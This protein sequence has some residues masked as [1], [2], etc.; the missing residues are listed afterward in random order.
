MAES[1]AIIP[2]VKNKEG[3][4]VDSILFKDLLKLNKYNRQD[5]VNA[6]LMTKSK[7]FSTYYG[8]KVEY[9]ENNEPKLNSL[10][11]LPEFKTI[12]SDN[13]IIE[14]LNKEIGH[15]KKDSNNIDY[16]KNNTEN[17]QSL[18]KKAIDFNTSAKYKDYIALIKKSQDDKGNTLLT[19]EVEKKN[20]INSKEASDMQ[21]FY[22]LNQK[23][24]EIMHD[25]GVTDEAL[26]DIEERLGINGVTDFEKANVTANGLIAII[27]L[28]KGER[29]EKALPEEFAHLMIKAL[30]DNPLAKRLR[31]V[32][33]K[34][35]LEAEILGE[36]YNTYS[37]QY[38]GNR[39]KLIEEAMGK[40]VANSLIN[41]Q[42]I[43]QAPYKP[44][45]QRLIQAIKNFF[46]NWDIDR[47]DRAK[48]EANKVSD[49]IAT[50]LLNNKLVDRKDIDNISSSDKFYQ[51]TEKVK[52]NKELI[53]SIIQTEAKRLKIFETKN[54]ETF[55]LKQQQVIL[56][57]QKSLKDNTE[58]EALYEYLDETFNTLQKVEAKLINLKS[59]SDVSINTLARTLND[60]KDFLDA[61]GSVFNIIR[62]R[63]VEDNKYEDSQFDDNLKEVLK[64][65]DD[66]LK[67]LYLEYKNYSMPL[68]VQFIKPWV[69]EGIVIPF[70][71][72]KGKI[73]TAEDMVKR[74]DQDISFFDRWLKSMA[75][76]SDP[77]LNILD[78]IVK[79]QKNEA[80]LNTIEISKKI[81]ALG[82]E[83]EQAGVKG[84]D[85]MFEKNKEGKRT[86]NY[87]QEINYGEFKE[88]LRKFWDELNKKYGENPVDEE[89]ILNRKKE[90]REWYQENT[91]RAGEQTIP[92]ISK[93]KNKEYEKLNDAQKKFY[94]EIIQIKADLEKSLPEGYKRTYRTVKIRKSLMERILSSENVKSGSL[95]FWES[96]KDQVIRR[97]DDNEFGTKSSVKDFEG[98][99]VMTLPI[100][101]TNLK[102]GESEEDVSTD[103]VSTMI[104]YAAMAED[105]KQM[106]K[107]LDILEL[108]RDVLR[109]REI[110][111]TEGGKVKQEVFNVLGIK[112]TSPIVKKGEGTNFFDRLQDFFTMQVYQRYMKDEGTFGST[113]IDKGKTANFLNKL[114]ALNS[115]ALNLLSGISNVTTGNIMMTVESF[116]KQFFSPSDTAKADKI[117][118]SSLPQ[119]MAE[120]G[121]RIKTSKLALWDELFNVLQE[122]EQENRD[123][124][125]LLN[126]M[127]KRLFGSSILYTFN[128][129]G[130]HWMQNRTSLAV[131]NTIKMKTPE[132]KI[133]SLWDAMEVQYIDKNNPKKGARLVV[134]EGYTKED[135][136]KF[137]R[138]DIYKA[139]QKMA[140]INHQ[141]HG[142]YN[143]LD[144]NAFQHV[145]LGRLVMM[146]RKYL[147]PSLHKRFASV[148]HNLDLDAWTEGYYRTLG[149]F[150]WQTAKELKQ[151]QF[152]IITNWNRLEP[153]EKANMRRSL[154][155][156]SIFISLWILI[157]LTDWSDKDKDWLSTMFEYQ[158]RRL[159][160]EIGALTPTPALVEEGLRI[161]KSPAAAVNT[162]EDLLDIVGALNPW[163]YEMV[164]G[165][166]A[167]IQSGKYKGHS[168][169]Y[170]D[171]MES[172]LFPI[173]NTVY[174]ALH[175]EEGIPFFK[176]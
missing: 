162:T 163:N 48:K 145:A 82:I 9:D 67:N 63:V 161:L 171:I 115:F 144:R 91:E 36:D 132:G 99:E 78:Q 55:N 54:R 90:I 88:N 62:E 174:R 95:T 164:G 128:N 120:I 44:L 173:K 135:G 13:K 83:L 121:Q 159:Y 147:V 119:Y 84:F 92:K 5:T 166:D 66:I 116:A 60:I 142:I 123:A 43:K 97:A 117:Y 72:H 158:A 34:N 77:I 39:S 154:T 87:I 14:S 134:K 52:K 51:V 16:K 27:R 10:I 1:C 46:K 71:K 110:V 172:P 61:Y 24:R 6:Y 53:N 137:T 160:S 146:Y 141:M 126:N 21:R 25:S 139:A 68:F 96:L 65:C 22:E 73:L 105:F 57:L 37:E 109:D 155:E 80:R 104:A 153:E 7:E 47:I 168:R 42:P 98:N 106:N 100:Y 70:G 130:E 124:K 152:A 40:L 15:Y 64:E 165:E 113:K 86:G 74:A 4:K 17:F 133:V 38:N 75:E 149:R 59:K 56:K 143:P 127:V 33:D 150:L 108:G 89:A 29:G 102:E 111:Q 107:V 151:G 3:K 156:L 79:K 11:R 30:G 170:K 12:L 93:Y 118:A 19:I 175:P 131:A 31:D 85:W 50:G 157:T 140:E 112:S 18:V 81:K 45:L 8:N 101:Y 76:S 103:V 49:I 167:I 69:G 122:Y 28:A 58:I 114:T 138:E 35:H 169:G 136:T 125:F 23:L 148:Q 2:C 176:N 32:I 20:D 94:K 26:T 129:I 41:N